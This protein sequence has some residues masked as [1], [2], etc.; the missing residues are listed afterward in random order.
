MTELQNVLI[1]F[2]LAVNIWVLALSIKKLDILEN[3]TMIHWRK[4]T[5]GLSLTISGYFLW[6]IVEILEDF[7]VLLYRPLLILSFLLL[8]LGQTVYLI[9]LY[10]KVT[11]RVL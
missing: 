9:I 5:L 7:S 3:L 8:S 2:G 11:G 10:R 4:V 1:L 6:F